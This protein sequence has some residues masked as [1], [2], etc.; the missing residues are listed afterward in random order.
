MLT[1]LDPE[2]GS[3]WKTAKG[4]RKK[5]SPISALTG[6]AGIAYSDTDKAETLADSLE[7]QFQLNNITNITSDNNHNSRS[8][9]LNLDDLT[10]ALS[11]I[12]NSYACLQLCSS[13]EWKIQELPYCKLDTPSTQNKTGLRLYA[14]LQDAR[15]RYLEMKKKELQFEQETMM[16]ISKQWCFGK[17]QEN[18]FTTVVSRKQK[19]SS[20][21]KITAG[22]KPRTEN[23]DSNRFS[24]LDIEEPPAAF[25]DDA[26]L[27]V[28][29]TDDPTITQEFHTVPAQA[30]TPDHN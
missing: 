15:A 10:Q 21:N 9:T 2:D 1:S 30:A 28:F 3:L 24:N 26:N 12:D 11:H 29:D 23:Q 8:A 25:Q 7:N 5:R 20:P 14:L 13:I 18:G 17:D 16:G 19:N 6:R 4:F 27:A 22:K